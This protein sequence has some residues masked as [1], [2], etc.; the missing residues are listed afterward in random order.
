MNL[1]AKLHAW[2]AAGLIQ[3]SQADR[4]LDF[5]HSKKIPYAYYSFI[6]LGIVVLATGIVALIAVN[7]EDIPDW[8]KLSIGFALLLSLGTGVVYLSE[9]KGSNPNWQLLL[10]LF[11]SLLC[12]GM[13]G[14]IS[15]IYHTQGELYQATGLWAA[16]T[17][18][19]VL[20]HPTKTFLHLW[21]FFFSFS[22]FDWI[23][24][25]LLWTEV[26]YWYS[27]LNLAFASSFGILALEYEKHLE[28]K[29]EA[30][31]LGS[32]VFLV[33]WIVYLVAASIF[34]SILRFD[35]DLGS[36]VSDNVPRVFF[37][38]WIA[39]ILVG[40]LSAWAFFSKVRIGKQRIVLF[41]LSSV[42][43][44]LLCLPQV[45][46][47]Y[48][49]FPSA[50]LF[51]LTWFFLSFLF[52]DSRRWFDFCL[53]VI[54]IRFIFIYFEI[55]G[56]LLETAWGL[57]ISGGVII[58]ASLLFFQQKERIRNFLLQLISSWGEK[59]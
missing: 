19:L 52:F 33:W 6:I 28:K 43:L 49:K 10:V 47:W 11:F 18:L 7:W 26:K 46:S 34:S 20:T 58:G 9:K 4:I 15:Q 44:I 51:I 5:E 27:L 41:L 32:N 40:L 12:F 37:P 25:R 36:S 38:R 24:S 56:S 55:F 57:I 31:T 42:A 23:G 54:G 50:F 2:V 29:E 13:I 22:V 21:I 17:F 16:M 3:S 45:L 48:G 30:K 53:V 59:K 35:Y 8:F 14:L 39:F 1:K